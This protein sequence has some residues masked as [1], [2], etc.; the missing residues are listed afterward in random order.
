MGDR[1]LE[2]F[3]RQNGLS[4]V[5]SGS[6]PGAAGGGVAFGPGT[7]NGIAGGDLPGGLF[8][9]IAWSEVQELPS[10]GEMAAEGATLGL[11]G[12][13]G[14][15]RR[16]RS[17]GADAGS[18][19]Y[20]RHVG[21]LLTRIPQSL[22]WLPYLVCKEDKKRGAADRLFG[23]GGM[24]QIIREIEFESINFERKYRVGVMAGPDGENKV[25]QLFSPTFVD[26][27]AD[28]A[29]E[30]LYFELGGG[31]LKVRAPSRE[32]SVEEAR[33]LC[34]FGARVAERIR[35]EVAESE[36]RPDQ[37]AGLIDEAM[38]QQRKKVEAEL[39]A[40]SF[41]RP[42]TS[43][44]DAAKAYR[45]ETKGFLGL[46]GKEKAR[47]LGYMAVM[48][49]YCKPRDLGLAMPLDFFTHVAR[50]ELPRTELAYLAHGPIPGADLT[51]EFASFDYS[52]AQD[53][54]LLAP[55]V[56]FERRSANSAPV[57]RILPEDRGERV[58]LGGFKIEGPSGERVVSENERRSAEAAEELAR[59]RLDSDYNVEVALSGEGSPSLPDAVA[60][61]L[62][63]QGGKGTLILDGSTACL[64][65]S[66]V[67]T[68]EWSQKLLD[69]FFAGI[70]EPIRALAA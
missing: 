13:K 49:A 12:P 16:W 34:E 35:S 41:D 18:T 22:T 69:E 51:G 45:K 63:A 9:A 5:E 60:E 30:D 68:E 2:E 56:F 61:W 46:G 4:Y 47:E 57:V 54:S 67:E 42:P 50:L 19:E 48:R 20:F 38:E 28:H 64:I 62:A 17:S 26:W 3:A 55:A 8:G 10:A 70:A 32:E 65:A 52:D 33:T 39:D 29:P 37:M 66:P 43:V 24:I 11:V 40:V 44:E 23:P 15:E 6:L 7:I 21:V 31:M 58:F 25:K 36:G 59:D 14:L 1:P 53:K 27:L